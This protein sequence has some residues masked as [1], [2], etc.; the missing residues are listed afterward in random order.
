MSCHATFDNRFKEWFTENLEQISVTLS[1]VNRSAGSQ[2]LF[3]SMRPLCVGVNVGGSSLC[4][5]DDDDDE[6]ERS[7][8]CCEFFNYFDMSSLSLAQ[9]NS[10]KRHSLSVVFFIRIINY[11]LLFPFS[12]AG[13]TFEQHEKLF[14][15]G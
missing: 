12:A 3:I 15:G 4:D 13:E 2:T 9:H 11:L 7:G 6:T 1:C 8:K 5:D 14:Q 10:R